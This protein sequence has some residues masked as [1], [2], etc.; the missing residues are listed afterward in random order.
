MSRVGKQPVPVPP[1]V[2]VQVDGRTVRAEGPKGKLSM[3]LPPLT[4]AR[5][6][7]NRIVVERL[8]DTKQAK[9]MHGLGRALVNNLVQGVAQGYQKR[10]EIHGVGFRASVQGNTL[11]LNLGFS[12]P[13]VY[14][15]PEGVKITVEENTRIVVEGAD[16]QKV[17]QVAAQIRS[18][19]PPE[20]YK[21]KGIRYEGE[22][23]IR[24]EGKAVQ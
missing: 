19:Y 4:S 12:H 7:G 15:A 24:K 14:Q 9:A 18:F 21:G 8:A 5:L 13:V 17:G 6:D 10:L 20:P 16:K 3:E 11:T 2:K 1:Q 22:Q 23:I